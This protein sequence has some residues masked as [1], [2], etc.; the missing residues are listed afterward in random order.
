M[1][2]L[3]AGLPVEV[4]G[5]TFNRLCASG[6]HAVADAARQIAQ[7]EVDLVIAGGVEHMTRAPWVMAKATEAFPRGNQTVFDT[8]L[9]WRFVNPRMQELHGTLAM[10]ETAEEV[11]RRHQVSREAQDQLAATSQRRAAAAL[12]SGR[13]E[14]ECPVPVG[15][16]KAARRGCSRWTSTRARTA[17]SRSWPGQAGSPMAPSPLETGDQ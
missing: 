11:A 9:G 17:P 1:A 16:D 5:V 15:K 6:M 7:G 8:T 12:E 4:P 13:F 14:R 10:G 3:L 2:L